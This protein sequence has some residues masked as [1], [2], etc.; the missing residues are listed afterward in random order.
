M[1]IK[2]LLYISNG[3]K[4]VVQYIEEQEKGVKEIEEVEDID[5]LEERQEVYRFN[6]EFIS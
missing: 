6:S 2:I 1:L 3:G 5:S 4:Q